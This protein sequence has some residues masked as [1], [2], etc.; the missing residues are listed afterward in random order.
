MLR[1]N[2]TKNPTAIIIQDKA[3]TWDIESKIINKTSWEEYVFSKRIR[4]GHSELFLGINWKPQSKNHWIEIKNI[5]VVVI[6]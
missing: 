4:P 5:S 3:E 2:K 6:N 1:S